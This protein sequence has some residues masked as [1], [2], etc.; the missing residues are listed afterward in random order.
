MKA[1]LAK[2]WL[3]EAD[4]GVVYS[5]DATPAAAQDVTLPAIPDQFNQLATYPI[6]ALAKAAQPDLAQQFI[7]LVLSDSGQQLLARYGFSSPKAR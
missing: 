3:G 6:S 1:V 2:V 4:A 7:E 5:T